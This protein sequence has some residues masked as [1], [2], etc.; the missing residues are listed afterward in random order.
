[1][2]LSQRAPLHAGTHPYTHA[3]THVHTRRTPHTTHTHTH[4]RAP[5]HTCICS[6]TCQASQASTIQAS[7]SSKCRSGVERHTI[8]CRPWTTQATVAPVKHDVLAQ[9][10][11]ST[12][13][14]IR[15]VV[16]QTSAPVNNQRLVSV[17]QRDDGCV[18]PATAVASVVATAATAVV[19]AAAA[20]RSAVVS[21]SHDRDGSST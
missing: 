21:C 5:C 20:A 7:T 1:M 4:A 2:S 3:H 11:R 19:A 10:E 8:G 18:T 6:C 16:D 15:H 9:L 13:A 14:T 17:A 12:A